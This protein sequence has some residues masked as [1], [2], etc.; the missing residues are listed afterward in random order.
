MQL[1]VREGE[2]AADGKALEWLAASYGG[3]GRKS[4]VQAAKG[5][6]QLNSKNGPTL[7]H[8]MH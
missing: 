4:A 5:H 6:T 1:E 3:K 7:P 2:G 8:T